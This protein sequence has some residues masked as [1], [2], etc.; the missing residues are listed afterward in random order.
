[1]LKEIEKR[2]AIQIM[3]SGEETM[4]FAHG[5]GCDQSMWRFIVPAFEK[6]FQIV[7]FDHIGSGN[8]DL[9]SYDSRKY[10]S[11][12]GYADDIIEIV[13]TLNLK[14]VTVVGHSVSA[15]ISALAA[16][17]APELFSRLILLV[18]SACY[19][20]YPPEYMGGFAREDLD[21]LLDLM[22]KNFIGWSSFLAPVI[23]KNED[24]PEL[25]DELEQSFC[26]LDPQIGQRF[27]EVTFLSDNRKDLEGIETPS[28][29]LQCE[30]DS[31]APPSA[32]EFVHTTI[33]NSV[34][35]SMEA[36]GHCPHMSQPK[37]TI[38]AIE[39]YL[40]DQ[41]LSSASTSRIQ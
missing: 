5:F 19:V 35:H 24:R 41:R 11:L 16:K 7:L 13:R 34:L 14:K 2:H 10:S 32:I 18:P 28:L 1:M 15:T 30:D 38:A 25:K 12:D 33:K 36:T 37:E 26:R 9:G 21:S 39:A 20:N 23:M 29:I 27:A 40:E 22:Q 6:R 8:S 31:I 4:V 17:K 3:G